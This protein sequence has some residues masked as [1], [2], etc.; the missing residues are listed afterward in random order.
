MRATV[1]AEGGSRLPQFAFPEAATEELGDADQ[2]LKRRTVRARAGSSEELGAD[3]ILEEIDRPKAVTR[4]VRAASPASSASPNATQ[5]VSVA[6]ILEVVDQVDALLETSDRAEAR[7][8]EDRQVEAKKVDPSEIAKLLAPRSSAMPEPLARVRARES[9]TPTSFSPVAL[10][11]ALPVYRVETPIEI[12]WDI[13]PPP[14]RSMTPLVAG[15]LVVAFGIV[16]AAVVRHGVRSDA[17]EPPIALLAPPSK[18]AAS[19]PPANAGASPNSATFVEAPAPHVSPITVSH[20][21]PVVDVTALPR[22]P[23]GTVVGAAGHRLFIDGHVARGASAEVKCGLHVVKV[24]SAGVSKMIDVPCGGEIT[25][26]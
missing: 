1:K 6:D 11:V 18:V 24:G 16:A 23:I 5:D 20:D 13:P 7:K 2:T 19:A 26:R 12:E 22:S 25:V 21:V 4:V 15:A 3:D 10:D 9:G 14:R 8:I 17:V